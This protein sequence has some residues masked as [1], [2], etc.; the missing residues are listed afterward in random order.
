MVMKKG[1][2]GPWLACTGYPEC[3]GRKKVEKK[4]KEP[5]LVGAEA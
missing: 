3:R 5:D 2:Y 1:R 4:E